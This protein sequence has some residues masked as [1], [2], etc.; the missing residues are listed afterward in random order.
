MWQAE[1]DNVNSLSASPTTAVGQILLTLAKFCWNTKYVSDTWHADIE[2]AL[3][4]V[5]YI[6]SLIITFVSQKL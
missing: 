6:L 1:A 3:M 4:M 2:G 5:V